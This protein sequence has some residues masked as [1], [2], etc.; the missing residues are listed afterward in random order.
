LDSTEVGF[1]CLKI[2]SEKPEA[3]RASMEPS[4]FLLAMLKRRIDLMR[5]RR[6][7]RRR[8]NRVNQSSSTGHN[9]TK[10]K[11]VGFIL[12]TSKYLSK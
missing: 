1:L 5:R 2:P 6:R 7:R 8:S 12:I 10:V 9:S 3:V 11:I 4:T